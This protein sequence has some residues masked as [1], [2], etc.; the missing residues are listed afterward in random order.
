MDDAEVLEG[1]PGTLA[2]EVS[3]YIHQEALHKCEVCVCFVLFCVLLC[4]VLCCVVFCACA[5]VFLTS[6]KTT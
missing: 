5:C 6:Q 4:V 3:I 2:T 1:L